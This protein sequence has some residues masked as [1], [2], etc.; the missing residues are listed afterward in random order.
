M[1]TVATRAAVQK[2]QKALRT[3]RVG[4]DRGMELSIVLE[5]VDDLPGHPK[6][7]RVWRSTCLLAEDGTESERE[8]CGEA[9]PGRLF[10][11]AI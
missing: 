7:R 9:P 3:S 1:E 10:G 5:Q 6:A 4:K 11:K 8:N 2:R